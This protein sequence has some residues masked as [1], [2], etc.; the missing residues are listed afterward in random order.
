M[1]ELN[2]ELIENANR[3]NYPKIQEAIDYFTERG[4]TPVEIMVDFEEL[5]KLLGVQPKIPVKRQPTED[6]GLP[7]TVNIA[8]RLMKS[9]RDGLLTADLFAGLHCAKYTSRISDLRRQGHLIDAKAEGV[10]AGGLPTNQWRYFW[11]GFTGKVEDLPPVLKEALKEWEPLLQ[12]KG[13]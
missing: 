6:L 10:L 12:S 7:Q 3:R 11:K 2:L 1:N 13:K 5:Q 8:L 9:G 4:E